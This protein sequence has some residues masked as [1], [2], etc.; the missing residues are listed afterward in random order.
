MTLRIKSDSLFNDLIKRSFKHGF[1]F[2]H[3]TKRSE[4][5]S[6]AKGL[7][8]RLFV[9]TV[10]GTRIRTGGLYAASLESV[11]H[12]NT[13]VPAEVDCPDCLKHA[14]YDLWVINSVNV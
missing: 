8:D 5:L 14:S 10:C 12:N 6:D 3:A 11:K 7:A 1:Q 13:R 2:T 9:H 4:G